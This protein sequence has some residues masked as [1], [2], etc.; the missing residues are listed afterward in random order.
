VLGDLAVAGALEATARGHAIDGREL[1]VR[2]VMA[3]D[4]FASCRLLYVSG[5]DST[6]TARLLDGV[7]TRPVLTISDDESFAAS[8]GI[9]ELFVENGRMRFAIN[10]M[11]AR[12]AGI[13][14]SAKILSLAKLVKDDRHAPR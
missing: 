6:T 10:V 3:D 7:G 11:A 14:L 12:R 13:T 8:G 1:R 4:P 2:T 5:V 9:A